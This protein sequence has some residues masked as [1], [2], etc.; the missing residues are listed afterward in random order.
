M[1]QVCSNYRYDSKYT[2]DI[3]QVPCSSCGMNHDGDI[4]A[5]KN[6]LSA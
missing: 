2:L 1:N 5:A 3:R 4:S 6:I